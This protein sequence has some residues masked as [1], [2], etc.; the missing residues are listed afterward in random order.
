MLS[1]AEKVSLTEACQRY[2]RSRSVDCLEYLIDRGIPEAVADTFL[3]GSVSDPIAG[4]EHVEGLLSIPYRTPTGVVGCK[5]RH[6]DETVPKYMGVTGQ[7]TGMYNVVDLHGDTEVIAICEG[8]LD[9]VIMSGVIGVPAVGIPGV[10]SW[11]PWFGKLFEPFRKVYIFAD[12]DVK[13]DG[14]NPGMQL[15]KKIKEEVERS[16]IIHLPSGQDVNSLYLAEGPEW[17]T[18][19]VEA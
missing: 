7:K 9:T 18:G 1:N 4:H 10:S 8:E 3:L 6:M 17:F 15:G 13:A 14:S 12:N 19:K 2:A 16:T 5:F 11:K